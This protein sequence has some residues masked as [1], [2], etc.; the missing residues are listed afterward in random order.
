VADLPVRCSEV[1]EWREDGPR[2]RLVMYRMRA[3]TWALASTV[4][5]L[6]T[7][8]LFSFTICFGRRARLAGGG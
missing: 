7:S 6:C 8:L 3:L 4:G 5:M 1:C 2:F